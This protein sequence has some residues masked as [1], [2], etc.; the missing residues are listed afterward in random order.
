[1]DWTNKVIFELGNKS[2]KNTRHLT[3]SERTSNIL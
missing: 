2:G 3:E 1:M